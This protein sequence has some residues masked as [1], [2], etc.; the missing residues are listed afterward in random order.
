MISFVVES[1]TRE[2]SDLLSEGECRGLLGLNPASR[3]SRLLTLRTLRA[4]ELSRHYNNTPTTTSM[5]PQARLPQVDPPGLFSRVT[6]SAIHDLAGTE[7]TNW[8]T[9]LAKLESPPFVVPPKPF[10]FLSLPLELRHATYAEVFSSPSNPSV[11]DAVALRLTCRTILSEIDDELARQIRLTMPNAGPY[12][13]SWPIASV[14]SPVCIM[15]P[16]SA[17]PDLEFSDRGQSIQLDGVNSRICR[18]LCTLPEYVRNV[19]IFFEN[20]NVMGEAVAW[21]YIHVAREGVMSCMNSNGRTVKAV[22]M[23]WG[24]LVPSESGRRFMV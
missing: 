17:L 5:A 13:L 16:L 14:C 15:L 20:G 18:V 11:S 8:G 4:F 2:A 22:E 7:D 3:F 1:S 10:P 21:H 9:A 24:D 19:R 6:Y 12:T 23:V